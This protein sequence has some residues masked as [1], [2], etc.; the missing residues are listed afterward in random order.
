M[1]TP[2]KQAT[3]AR[4]IEIVRNAG[5]VGIQPLDLVKILVAEGY[6]EMTARDAFWTLRPCDG[7]VIY[8]IND[9]R[10]VAH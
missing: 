4:L 1:K 3:T 9:M 7:N 5:P 2:D 6:H 10:V 8:F